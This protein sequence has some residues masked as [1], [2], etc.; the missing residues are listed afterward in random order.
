MKNTTGLS[1]GTSSI[2]VIFI[3]LCLIT[4]A[5]L[6]LSTTVTSYRLSQSTAN[7]VTA[8]YNA[9]SSANRQLAKI[10]SILISNNDYALVIEQNQL[11]TITYKDNQTLLTFTVPIDDN[12]HLQV[13]LLLFPSNDTRYSIV[14]WKKINTF[15]WVPDDNI[16]VFKQNN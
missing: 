3:L 1:I 9:D 15:D 6:G 2:F 12:E 13:Q 10:D 8:F 16:P 5:A 7:H 11:G 4:F 14:E